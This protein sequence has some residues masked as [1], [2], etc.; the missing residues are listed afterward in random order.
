MKKEL[1]DA[2]I[3]RK[4]VSITL[5]KSLISKIGTGFDKLSI[6]D[7]VN[8]AKIFIPKKFGCHR[9]GS[10]YITG[11]INDE[12]RLCLVYQYS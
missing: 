8:I 5:L 4:R 1:D 12:R 10:K 6:P 3:K 7:S 11:Y 2:E 9:K